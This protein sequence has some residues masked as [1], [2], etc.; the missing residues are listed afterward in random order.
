MLADRVEFSHKTELLKCGPEWFYHEASTGLWQADPHQAGLRKIVEQSIRGYSE[1]SL[2]DER[3]RRR[4]LSAK[5]IDDVVK[6]LAHR[7]YDKGGF[8]RDPDIAGLPGGQCVDLRTGETR[9]TEKADRLTMALAHAPEPGPCPRFERYLTE[10]IPDEPTR[11]Y[12][13]RWLGYALTG[14]MGRIRGPKWRA[15]RTAVSGRAGRARASPL[16][17]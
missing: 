15:S 17:R 11:G 13:L 16:A 5:I 7:L 3:G 1:V 4:L 6:I 2:F 12:V 9:E 14:R 10:A 8:D